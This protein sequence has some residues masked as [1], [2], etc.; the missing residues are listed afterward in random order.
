[1]GY[2]KKYQPVILENPGPGTYNVEV[3][4]NQGVKMALSRE[5]N[6]PLQILI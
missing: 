4:N 2:G 1:M 6:L 5:V 3:K